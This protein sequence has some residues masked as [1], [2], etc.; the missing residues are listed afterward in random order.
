[1]PKLIFKMTK[2]PHL[3]LWFFDILF[4]DSFLI[5]LSLGFVKQTTNFKPDISTEQNFQVDFELIGIEI[6][7][8]GQVFDGSRDDVIDFLAENDMHVQAKAGH[9]EFFAKNLK[10]QIKSEL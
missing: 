7:H 10:K 8:A 4:F 9:D 5:M 6:I 3:S 2:D 1:M